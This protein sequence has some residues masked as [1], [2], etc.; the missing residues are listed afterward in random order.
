MKSPT[1][2]FL[3]L[4]FIAGIY[5]GLTAFF[6]AW[7]NTGRKKRKLLSKTRGSIYIAICVPGLIF[8]IYIIYIFCG[9]TNTILPLTSEQLFRSADILMLATLVVPALLGTV[10]RA[11]SGKNKPTE[12]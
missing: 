3:L 8:T 10:F 6:P 5:V 4:L 2:V 11:I 9:G 7:R 1:P 12:N